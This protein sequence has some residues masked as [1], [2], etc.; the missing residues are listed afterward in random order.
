MPRRLRRN[1]RRRPRRMMR[2]RRNVRRSRLR[3]SAVVH[4]FKRTCKLDNVSASITAAGV[5]S[6]IS[7]AYQFTL[8]S[9]PNYTEFTNLYDMYKINAIKLSFVPTASEYINSTTSSVIAQNG[10]QRFNSVLD[11]DDTSVPVSEN[12]LLQYATLKNTPGTRP[13]VRYFKPR[14]LTTVEEIVGATLGSSST[15]PRWIS[16]LSPSVEHLGVKI[17]VPPPVAG[18]AIGA[19]ITYTVYATYYFQCRNTK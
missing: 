3:A 2:K 16:C 1:F 5:Q 9:L 11:Y 8:D 19:A 4:S 6:G 7:Q 12:E 18:S 10:F 15:A 17:F 14:I 13:H